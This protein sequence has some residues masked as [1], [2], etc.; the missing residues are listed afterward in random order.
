MIWNREQYEERQYPTPGR[1]LRGHKAAFESA[2]YPVNVQSAGPG[3]YILVVTLPTSMPQEIDPYDLPR[4]RRRRIDL[5]R[6]ARGLVLAMIAVS[7]VYIAYSIFVS[8]V[9][10]TT[11]SVAKA[12]PEPS[13]WDRI[14]DAVPHGEPVVEHVAPAI[15]MPWDATGRH[16]GETVEGI[17]RILTA[18]FVAALF[19][20]LAFVALKVRKMVGK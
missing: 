3:M 11:S 7:L 6:L 14:A 17:G 2:G 15:E 19:A 20:A 1:Y 18:G 8:G 9:P 16:V 10:A 5:P 12:T 4:R 13:L